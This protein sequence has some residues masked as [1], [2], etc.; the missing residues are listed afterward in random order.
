MYA[1]VAY[2]RAASWRCAA[3]ELGG[4]RLLVIVVHGLAS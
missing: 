1:A 4:I 3:V 2:I